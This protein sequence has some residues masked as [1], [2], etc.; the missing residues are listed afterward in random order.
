MDTSLKITKDD[1]RI[2]IEHKLYCSTIGSLLYLTTNRVDFSFSI[3]VCAWF[4]ANPKVS[5][6]NVVKHSKYISIICEYSTRYSASLN[7][8]IVDFQILIGE[9]I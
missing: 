5:H 2:S 8:S 9:E 7:I 1:D 3:G 6:L 4:Q